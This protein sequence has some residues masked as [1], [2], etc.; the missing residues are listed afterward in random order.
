MPHITNLSLGESKEERK[1][2]EPK[3]TG[4]ELS[5]YFDKV[6]YKLNNFNTIAPQEFVKEPRKP[7]PKK[8]R[9]GVWKKYYNDEEVGACFCCN[10]EIYQKSSEI[11][12]TWN[13]GHIISDYDGGKMTIENMRPVC[14]DCNQKMK[15]QNMLIFKN[16]YYPE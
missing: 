15:T 5:N 4:I 7:I 11:T 8:L 1:M 9:D 2:W 6:S 3:N 14:F 10:K 13:C 12:K 16:I